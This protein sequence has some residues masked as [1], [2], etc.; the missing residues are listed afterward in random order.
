MTEEHPVEEPREEPAPAEEQEAPSLP[1]DA[2]PAV[3]PA[4][5]QAQIEELEKKRQ[6]AEADW[7]Y[8][9]E[10]KAKARKDYFQDKQPE[11]K[12]YPAERQAI[13]EP[14]ESDFTTYD[15]YIKA[16]A[17]H[18]AESKFRELEDRRRQ[19][20]E[21][22]RVAEKQQLFWTKMQDGFER[23]DDFEEVAFAPTVPITQAM[24]EIIMESD[25]AADIAYYL[26][27]N[28]K[29]CVQISRMTPTQAARE[30]GRIEAEMRNQ[31]SQIHGKKST[32]QAPPPIR[33]VAGGSGAIS[34]DPKKMSYQEYVKWRMEGGGR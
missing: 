25:A 14:K 27:K 1:E 13:S 7:K 10:E 11:K 26:G 24:S 6:K 17:D 9:R 30:I 4:E 18:R 21:S 2:I 23:Y 31:P 20:L 34:K 5:L 12:E 16:L 32:T 15:D 22:E 28:L 8:W 29:E 19:Q 3:D 33:P